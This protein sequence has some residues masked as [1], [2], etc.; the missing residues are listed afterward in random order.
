M[1]TTPASLLDRL[2]K[3]REANA[4][5]RFVELY[6]PLLFHWAK[7]LGQQ[8]S[9]A[10]DLVQDVFL[11]LLRKL[12]DFQY[13]PQRSFHCWLK[14]LFLNQHRERLRSRNALPVGDH[15]ELPSPEA[16]DE[17]ED[18]RFLTQQALRLIERDFSPIQWKAFK[19]YALAGRPVEEIAREL[20]I[21]RGTV[22]SVKSK[23][24]YRLRR[25]FE[26]LVD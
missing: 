23:V 11:R 24:V 18:R 10:A 8:D 25:E 5:D 2:G 14:T 6:S 7:Q 20:G 26:R 19:E 1:F 15:T 22:Y 3:P 12:P 16:I 21:S 9:D 4:W 13:D 17:F